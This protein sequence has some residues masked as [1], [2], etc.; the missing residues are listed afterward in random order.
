MS[1]ELKSKIKER[2]K[3]IREEI[4]IEDRVFVT[5]WLNKIRKPE[6]V[7]VTKEN[8][9]SDRL[10]AEYEHAYSIYPRCFKTYPRR[11]T[12]S[13]VGGALTFLTIFVFNVNYNMING[14]THQALSRNTRKIKKLE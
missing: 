7:E 4:P 11:A 6:F 9:L 8:V 10:R 2:L 5:R 13:F 12:L 3:E 14:T 1:K